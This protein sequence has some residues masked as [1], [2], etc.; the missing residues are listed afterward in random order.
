[1]DDEY[2]TK[3]QKGYQCKLNE[4]LKREPYECEAGCEQCKN[5]FCI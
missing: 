2:W 5:D 1:L 4:E 3:P